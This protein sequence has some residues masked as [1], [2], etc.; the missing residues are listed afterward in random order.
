[1][2]CN[3][4]RQIF[5]TGLTIENDQLQL[6]FNNVPTISN[7]GF[8]WFRF[9]QNLSLPSDYSNLPVYA[10][11][12]I[13]GTATLVPVLNKYGNVMLGKKIILNRNGN[14]CTR[15]VYRVYTGQ[16]IANDTPEY[17]LLMSNIPKIVRHYN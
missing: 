5:V 2:N 7:E 14:V 17:H 1:M 3:C 12:M 16:I 11:V 6:S 15:S 9:S 10:N 8:L 4:T 13:N